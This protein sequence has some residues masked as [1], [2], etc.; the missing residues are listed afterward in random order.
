MHE[1][2]TKVGESVC[3]TSAYVEQEDHLWFALDDQCHVEYHGM[4]RDS[5]IDNQGLDAIDADE[6]SRRG[7]RKGS[8]ANLH[9]KPLNNQQ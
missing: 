5:F 8:G 3:P 6:L 2:L 4:E 7:A 1:A 9:S